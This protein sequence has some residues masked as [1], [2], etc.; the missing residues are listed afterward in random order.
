MK[1]PFPKTWAAYLA[2]A[3]IHYGS[4]AIFKTLNMQ[5]ELDDP[6]STPYLPDGRRNVFCIWHDS[7]IYA[8]YGGKHNRIT[9]LVS[10]HRDGGTLVGVLNRINIKA[11]RGSSSRGGARAVT[12]LLKETENQHIVITPDG[13]RGPARVVKDGIVYVAAKTQKPVVVSGFAASSYWRIKGSWTDQ[14]V[15]KPFSTVHLMAGKPIYVPEDVDRDGIE[16]YRQL[17]QTEMDDIDRRANEK[18]GRTEPE[19]VYPTAEETEEVIRSKAA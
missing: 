7:M 1:I 16:E 9:A 2:S 8:S 3:G 4:K 11:V 14:I 19:I 12:K 17:I 13:P 5:V 18:L 15:P 6:E 10:Q